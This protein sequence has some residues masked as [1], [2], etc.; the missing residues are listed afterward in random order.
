MKL[1]SEE[2]IGY[3]FAL[4]DGL[5]EMIDIFFGHCLCELV[6][7]LIAILSFCNRFISF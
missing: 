2:G 4:G 5:K 3:D 6:K 1:L 7:I